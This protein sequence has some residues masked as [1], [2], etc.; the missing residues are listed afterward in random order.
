MPIDVQ[1]NMVLEYYCFGNGLGPVVRAFS[2]LGVN[3]VCLGIFEVDVG[4]IVANHVLSGGTVQN[5]YTKTTESMIDALTPFKIRVNL[6]NLDREQL[7]ILYN[8]HFSTKNMGDMYQVQSLPTSCDMI[9]CCF[10]DF[11]HTT[12]MKKVLAATPNKPRFLLTQTLPRNADR[13]NQWLTTLSEFGYY[14][15]SRTVRADQCGVPVRR[16][17]H[18]IVSNMKPFSLHFPTGAKI[19]PVSHFLSDDSH[20]PDGTLLPPGNV[21]VCNGNGDSRYLSTLDQLLL[22]GYTTADYSKV[23][24]YVQ[25]AKLR[26]LLKSSAPV[27]TF[28]QVFNSIFVSPTYTITSIVSVPSCKLEMLKIRSNILDIL[29]LKYEGKC[30]ETYGFISSVLEIKNILDAHVSSADSSNKFRVTYT[31][32]SVKPRLN[33]TY[34]GEVKVCC[35]SGII[36]TI[37]PF[38]EMGFVCKVLI[39]NNEFDNKAK[40]VYFSM[41]ECIFS[42]GDRTTFQITRIDYDHEQNIFQCIGAHRCA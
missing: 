17:R 18:F 37:G 31:I 10:N 42:K 23:S 39:T 36:T 8:A 6:A 7:T 21:R 32:R 30:E 14:S 20:Y 9:I 28:V 25:D 15:V 22:S 29:K 11:S 4:A 16:G 3:V 13:V 41:C 27:Y 33:N 35:R 34:S 5:S 38:E 24:P 19:A 1:T 26:Q 2:K 12:H 40:T